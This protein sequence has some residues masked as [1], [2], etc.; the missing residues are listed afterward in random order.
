M[1][2]HRYNVPTSRRTKPATA[3]VYVTSPVKIKTGAYFDEDKKDIAIRV[4]VPD[5]C[6]NDTARPAKASDGPNRW[7]RR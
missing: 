7:V 1:K 3:R 2:G 6:T 5:M 4:L